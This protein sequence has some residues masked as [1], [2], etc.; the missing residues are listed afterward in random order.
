M[1]RTNPGGWHGSQHVSGC[2]L[3]V[4]IF[5]DMA[6]GDWA[7]HFAT[8]AMLGFLI[9]MAFNLFSNVFGQDGNGFR[10]VVL[11]GVPPRE[12]LLGKNLALLPYALVVGSVMIAIL[13]WVHPVPASHVLANVVQLFILYLVG[14]ML[15][16]SCSIRMPWPMSPTSMGMRN[17]TATSFLASFLILLLLVVAIVPLAL[18]IWVEKWFAQGGSAIP[19]Y[20]IFSLIEFALVWYIYRRSLASKG[21]LL[22]ERIENV[23]ERVTQPID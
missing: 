22:T 16:N 3:Y 5:Q 20:L 11:A 9:M 6:Q 2:M 4:I 12:L 1:F 13:Q 8:L 18:P 7:A 15:G 10:A 19:V 23:L 21:R 17:A 14:C